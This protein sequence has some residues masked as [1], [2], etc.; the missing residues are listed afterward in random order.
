MSLMMIGMVLLVAAA[1]VALLAL[2]Y[3]LGRTQGDDELLRIRLHAAHAQRRMHD[4][5]RQA[6]TAMAESAEQHRRSGDGRG[7]A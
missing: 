3:W 7:Q 2:G 5:T 6:F 4:L 1:S